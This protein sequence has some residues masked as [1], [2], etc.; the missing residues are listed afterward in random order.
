M[1]E[2]D[3]AQDLLHCREALVHLGQRVF[4]QEPRTRVARGVPQ[5]RLARTAVDELL[6]PRRQP[7]NLEDAHASRV[8]GVPAIPAARSVDELVAVRPQVEFA[9]DGGGG[10]IGLAA[11][12]ADSSCDPLRDDEVG[13]GRDEQ[14]FDP[15][16][17]NRSIAASDPFVCSV[18]KTRC[19]VSAA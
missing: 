1:L 10:P 4:Q 7:E 11:G 8:P 5:F 2:A 9:Q 15:E 17:E 18:L 13:G 12:R 14:R 19:P 3:D 6:D 16:V